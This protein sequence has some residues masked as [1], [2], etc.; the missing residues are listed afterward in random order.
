MRRA[1]PPPEPDDW[2]RAIC[3]LAAR[4]LPSWHWPYFRTMV[5]TAT[6]TKGRHLVENT[7]VEAVR[8][9]A[10]HRQERGRAPQYN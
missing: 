5:S 4:L 7:L 10:T 3:N 8:D 1:L 6:S 9:D 2:G